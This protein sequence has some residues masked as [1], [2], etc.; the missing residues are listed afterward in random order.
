MIGGSVS[1]GAMSVH[2]RGADVQHLTAALFNNSFVFTPEELHHLIVEMSASQVGIGTE[3]P[4]GETKTALFTLCDT[5][6]G[7]FRTRR[8]PRSDCR[9]LPQHQVRLLQ[10][11]GWSASRGDGAP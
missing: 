5:T 9:E 10:V 11:A 4:V 6:A 7:R 8:G 1:T 2:R 3:Y